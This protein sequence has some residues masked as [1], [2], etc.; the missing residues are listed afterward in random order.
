MTSVAVPAPRA[1]APSRALAFARRN[2]LTLWAILALVYILLPIA[3]VILFSFNDPP[4]R[5]N[6]TWEQFTFD[7]WI[8]W[9]A[10]S[11][12]RS[13]VWLSLPGV[14]AGTLLTF[15]PAMGD[16]INA[17]LLGTPRQAMIGNVVQSK[18]LVITDYPEA[19]ALSFVLMAAI[20]VLIAVYTRVLGTERMGV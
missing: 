16:F 13:S 8:H 2:L 6:Y 7:N 12:I 9:D 17:E 3:V 11:G 19:A 14:F 20:L 1:S 18:F 10:V 4:G 5:F 15:I